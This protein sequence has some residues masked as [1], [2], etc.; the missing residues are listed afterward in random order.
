MTQPAPPEEKHPIA[1]CLRELGITQVAIIDDAYDSPTIESFDKDEIGDFWTAIERE[2]EML[3]ELGQLSGR[4]VNKREDIDNQVI[5]ELWRGLDKL[6][7]LKDPCTKQL[8]P[9]KIEKLSDLDAL[10]H[11]LKYLGLDPI[12]IGFENDYLPDSSIKLIFLDY[13]LDPTETEN[14]GKLATQKATEIYG[15][16][17]SPDEKPFIVL[18]SSYP[19]VE[20]QKERFREGSSLLG[21]LFGFIEKKDIQDRE[22]LYLKLYSLGI[23]NP[24]HHAIQRFVDTLVELYVYSTS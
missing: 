8:F 21:G 12:T 13:V 7:K 17:K 2:Q 23:G 9:T 19:N 11:H 18:I 10:S 5:R 6:E 3:T 22:K 24:T 16:I 20:Q 1:D 4:E 15:R 14:P